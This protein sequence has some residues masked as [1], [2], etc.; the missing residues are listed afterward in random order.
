[1]VAERHCIA[2]CDMIVEYRDW[3]STTNDF[4]FGFNS[5]QAHLFLLK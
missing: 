3:N 5:Y 2:A 4:L 1:M